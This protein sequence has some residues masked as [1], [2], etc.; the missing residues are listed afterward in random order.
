MFRLTRSPDWLFAWML[1]LPAVVLLTNFTYIPAIRSFINSLFFFSEDGSAKFVAAE[2]FS[3]LLY[4]DV[5]IM[6][7]TNNA[8]YALIT[9]PVSMF[10]ALT[11]ALWVN[12][13]FLGRSALRLSFFV[14][15][16]CLWWRLPIS[17]CFST[18]R[19]SGC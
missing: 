13:K 12:E 18:R 10:L 6:A 15:T 9:V 14:P 16:C 19:T 3:D 8:W 4:D 11:M 5:F 17:G 2:N 7:L 1:L